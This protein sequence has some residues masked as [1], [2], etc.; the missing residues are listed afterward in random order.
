MVFEYLTVFVSVVVGLAITQLLTHLVRII[1]QRQHCRVYW[2]HLIWALN[3]F[4]WTVAYWWFTFSMAHIEVWTLSL[5]VFVLIYAI[6]LYVLMA[7]LFPED[8]APDEDYRILFYR[9]QRW[10]F[11]VLLLFLSV[12][13]I[14]FWVKLETDSDIV[15]IGP[16]L[17]FILPLIGMAG[18]AA[19]SNNERFHKIFAC[20]FLL[21]VSAFSVI[22]LPPLI[23][24]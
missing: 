18:V 20:V 17:A 23:S 24:G 1:H 13:L 19:F 16:F 3:I 10:F 2:V 14:D 21:W 9:N 15:T 22:T 12:D 7:L 11:G 5:F 8:V 6:L 4:I